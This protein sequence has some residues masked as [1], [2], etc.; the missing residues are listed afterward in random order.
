MREIQNPNKTLLVIWN[1][2][3]GFIWNL[4]FEICNFTLFLVSVNFFSSLRF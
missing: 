3:L 1:C 4:G 2:E